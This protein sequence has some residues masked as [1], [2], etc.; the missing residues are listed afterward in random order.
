M[1]DFFRRLLGRLSRRQEES[2]YDPDLY[3]EDDDDDGSSPPG[4]RQLFTALDIGTAYAKA[5]IIEIEGDQA[6]VL[7]VGRHAQSYAHMSDGIVTDISG[8]IANCNEALLQAQKMAGG[9]IAPSAVIAI[10]GEL[11]K[12]S[13]TTISRQRQS[14]TKA[15][16]AEELDGLIKLAQQQLRKSAK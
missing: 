4:Q 6:E 5:L 15:V 10:A 2:E 8:V 14:S 16:S 3:R 7:G 11:V 12:G 13:S 9:A 1:I